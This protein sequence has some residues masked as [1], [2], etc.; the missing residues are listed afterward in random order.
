M[1]LVVRNFIIQVSASSVPKIL[2]N[3]YKHTITCRLYN[4]ESNVHLDYHL[5]SERYIIN[6]IVGR[7]Y[8]DKS[9]KTLYKYSHDMLEIKDIRCIHQ[10]IERK[11]DGSHFVSLNVLILNW[12]KWFSL[13]TI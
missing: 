3:L 13:C 5:C 8:Y 4:L 6:W 10:G 7:F 1:C 11:E 12:N 9:T 2:N